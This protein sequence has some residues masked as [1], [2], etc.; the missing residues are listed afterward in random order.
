MFTLLLFTLPIDAPRPTARVDAPIDLGTLSITE[1]RLL[2]GVR[3]RF[4]VWRRS[5]VDECQGRLHF[6][7][8]NRFGHHCFVRLAR[9]ETIGDEPDSVVIEGTLR[10]WDVPSYTLN[11]KRFEGWTMIRIEWGRVR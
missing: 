3:G 8:W 11:G 2:H 4:S 9:G 6:D 7:A 10:V 5:L 1:A